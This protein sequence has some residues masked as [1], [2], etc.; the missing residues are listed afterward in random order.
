MLIQSN[1][2]L[3]KEET[4]VFGYLSNKKE[5]NKS[6]NHNDSTN[7]DDKV[8]IQKRI[9]YVEHQNKLL[10]L[11]LEKDKNYQEAVIKIRNCRS[12]I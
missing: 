1:I 7:R 8:F 3:E 10:L 12:Q 4:E 9:K 11:Q 2:P 6:I 5:D